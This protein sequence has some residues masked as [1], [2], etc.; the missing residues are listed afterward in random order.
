MSCAQPQH[1][2]SPVICG[3]ESAADYFSNEKILVLSLLNVFGLCLLFIQ[4]CSENRVLIT[5]KALVGSSTRRHHILPTRRWVCLI[6]LGSDGGG[7][8][9]VIKWPDIEKA[10]LATW[11]QEYRSNICNSR[12]KHLMYINKICY[13]LHILSYLI[14]IM[15]QTFMCVCV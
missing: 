15:Q 14:D 1:D 5:R 12:G 7:C 10:T 4:P 2:A 8:S 3:I 13:K 9:F 11:C 6:S